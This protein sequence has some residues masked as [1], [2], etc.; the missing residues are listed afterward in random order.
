MLQSIL[1]FVVISQISS[2]VL[3][4]FQITKVFTSSPDLLSFIINIA[5]VFI[6][7]IKLYKMLQNRSDYYPHYPIYL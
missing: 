4:L 5:T 2:S 6:T 1:E 7:V 3:F